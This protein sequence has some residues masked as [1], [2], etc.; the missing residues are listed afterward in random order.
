MTQENPLRDCKIN[1]TFDRRSNLY[2]V[3]LIENGSGTSQ[4]VKAENVMETIA[5]MITRKGR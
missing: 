3:H 1:V 4:M 2:H 5:Q